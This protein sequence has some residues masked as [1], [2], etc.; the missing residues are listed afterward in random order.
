M[1]VIV[2]QKIIIAIIMKSMGER[3]EF[4][5]AIGPFAEKVSMVEWN[6]AMGRG[7]DCN[8]TNVFCL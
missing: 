5:C 6:V 2:P 8:Q 3:S 4:H 7:R 1:T